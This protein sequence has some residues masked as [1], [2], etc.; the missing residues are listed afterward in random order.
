ME[1]RLP[2]LLVRILIVSACVVESAKKFLAALLMSASIRQFFDESSYCIVVSNGEF[3]RVASHDC[4]S[5]SENYT[6]Q[7]SSASAIHQGCS[8]SQISRSARSLASIALSAIRI[9]SEAEVCAT[10]PRAANVAPLCVIRNLTFVPVTKGVAVATK[11]PNRLRL[12][13]RVTICSSDPQVSHLNS[14]SQEM[15]GCATAFGLHII[16]MRPVLSGGNLGPY[17]PPR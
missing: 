11:Q 5:V 4:T 17:H 13:A 9:P 12:R 8:A 10:Q 2:H 1:E 3:V 15:A 7:E 14:S 6:V 16:T